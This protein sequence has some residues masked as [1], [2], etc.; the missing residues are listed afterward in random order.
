MDCKT[1]KP[2][3]SSCNLSHNLSKK[4]FSYFTLFALF[5]IHFFVT[6]LT[7]VSPN[8]KIVLINYT[9]NLIFFTILIFYVFSIVFS[10]IVLFFYLFN[11]YTYKP[12][13]NFSMLPSSEIFFEELVNNF[14]N[15]IILLRN[16]F[17]ILSI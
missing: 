14:V 5:V 16:S 3:S 13:S 8:N 2:P 11:L 12:F 17:F 15:M 9:I 10:K 6:I 1:T 4:L 7:I